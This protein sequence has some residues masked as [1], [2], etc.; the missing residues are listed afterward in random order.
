[1]EKAQV[2]AASGKSTFVEDEIGELRKYIMEMMHTEMELMESIKLNERDVAAVNARIKH[3][4][5]L[6]TEEQARYKALK[7]ELEGDTNELK[8]LEEKQTVTEAKH[9]Q[10]QDAVTQRE[11]E[12]QMLR[13]RFQHQRA[14]MLSLRCQILDATKSLEK[15]SSQDESVEKETNKGA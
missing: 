6:I 13:A 8:N 12:V 4:K 3:F 10:F 1:M 15:L 14:A 11:S 7:R 5:E 2:E 9:R